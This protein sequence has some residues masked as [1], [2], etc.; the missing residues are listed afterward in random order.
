MKLLRRLAALNLWLAALWLHPAAAHAQASARP[1]AREVVVMTRIVPAHFQIGSGYGGGYGTNQARRAR[2]HVARRIARDNGL[3]ITDDWPMPLIDMACFVMVVPEGKSVDDALSQLS[4]DRDVVFAEPM[5]LYTAQSAP[6]S[7][8]DPLYRA[9]P[10][11]SA[12]RLAALHQISTGRGVTVALVDSGI[13]TTHPDLSGQIA[14][15]V[16]FVTAS[17]FRAESHGTAVAGVIAAKA[18]N[19]VG[20]VGIAPGARLWGLRACWQDGRATVCDTVSLAKALH[21]AIDHGAEVI[22][23]SLAGPYGEL[24]NRLLDTA[25]ARRITVVGAYDSGLP[26]GGFPASHRG[27]VAV[28]ED[29]QRPV[30]PGVYAAPG[31]NVITTQLGGKWNVASGSS[32]AAAQ[33]SGL[34]ALMRARSSGGGLT[35]VTLRGDNAIDACATLL[36]AGKRCDCDC[37]RNAEVAARG[38]P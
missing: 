16:N 34:F 19:H 12:W 25:L 14:S 29:G 9:Q 31:R 1:Q 38:A 11:A 18:G 22:N 4:H 21:Y 8:D 23:M 26:N 24:L 7:Y 27:V 20:I 2:L 35:L 6:A 10:A 15:N 32:F 3:T 36:R 5:H 37:A 30:R 17:P 13:E 28:A 33:V